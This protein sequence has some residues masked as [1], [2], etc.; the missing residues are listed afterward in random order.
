MS[1][2]A[3]Y[4]TTDPNNNKQEALFMYSR[5]LREIFINMETTEEEVSTFEY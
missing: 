2:I 5:L 1:F 4:S 3:S